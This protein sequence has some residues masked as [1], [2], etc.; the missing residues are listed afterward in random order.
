MAHEYNVKNG[1][2]IAAL[3]GMLKAAT[4]VVSVAVADTDYQ[5]V[6][7]WGD[8]LEYTTGT[9]SVDFNTTNLKITSN[10]INT[11]QDIDTTA[12][13][14]FAGLTVVNAITEFSTDGTLAG[15][16][17]SA[18]PTEKAVKTY[19]DT[20]FAND[21]WDRD[22]TVLSAHNVGDTISLVGEDLQE[23]GDIVGTT[24]SGDRGYVR[25]GN[26]VTTSHSLDSD[27]DLLVT[28]ELEVKGLVFLDD[29]VLVA[30]DKKV[31]F[32][33]AGVYIF[34]DDDGYLDIVADTGI[35][36]SGAVS[37][38]NDLTLENG[39]IIANKVNLVIDTGTED[40][41]TFS[42]TLG[43]ACVF[44]YVVKK[45]ANLRAGSIT[46]CWDSS[47]DAVEYNETC[48]EDIGDTSDLEF[49]IDIDT[50]LVRLRAVAG[51]DSWIVRVIRNLI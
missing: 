28:G 41:D 3:S 4:G 50:N 6:I 26:A 47:G 17:D 30:L 16:S 5:Q 45:G 2:R 24:G 23:V 10:E 11:I 49:S 42:D 8:G 44:H 31:Q 38:D 20:Q 48:T 12:S 43:D 22:G 14:T 25:V 9:A 35:R 7:S 36:V 1:L 40:V 29:D 39:A 32:G 13:P 46:V 21:Y 34:S 51:S 33:D 27:D 37:F 19:V 15:D 18:L